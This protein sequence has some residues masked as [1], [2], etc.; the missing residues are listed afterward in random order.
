MTT[1]LRS[2]LVLLLA[3]ALE[4][5]Q[6]PAPFGTRLGVTD[7][8]VDVY[9]CNL[10]PGEEALDMDPNYV[11]GV[12]TGVRWQCVELAR[13]YLYINY[14]VIF[15]DVDYAFQIYD[16]PA[17]ERVATKAAVAVTKHSNGAATPPRLGSLLIWSAYGEMAETGHVAVVVNVTDTHVDIAEQN[18]ED[19]IWPKD[20]LYSRRLQV[21][22]NA[23]SYEVQKWYEKEH[24]IGWIT[25]D[26]ASPASVLDSTT[27]S[28]SSY[29]FVF[30]AVIVVAVG[31]FVARR[32]YSRRSDR[33]AQYDYVK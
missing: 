14:G 20:R 26:G 31:G 27:S 33:Y 12:Y 2:L 22:R 23:T 24:I 19:T 11:D 15:G 18:V 1:I 29:G 3:I 30:A 7:G 21:H 28:S 13:R 32:H 10:P 8:G 16:L 6:S 4:A 25:V 9:S 5:A 17:F